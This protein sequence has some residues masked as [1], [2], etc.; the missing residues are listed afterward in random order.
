MLWLLLLKTQ[1]ISKILHVV[2]WLR[3]DLVDYGEQNDA[4]IA[5]HRVDTAENKPLEASFSGFTIHRVGLSP[6]HTIS[7]DRVRR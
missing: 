7:A 1:K 4:W 6:G 5:E 2:T 3:A